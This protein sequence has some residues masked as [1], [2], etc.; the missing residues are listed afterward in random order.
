MTLD[1]VEAR[2]RNLAKLE[3]K[4]QT[5]RQVFEEMASLMGVQDEAI[6][7]LELQIE[8]TQDVTSSAEITA[9][10]AKKYEKRARKASYLNILKVLI[11]ITNFTEAMVAAHHGARVR[12]IHRCCHCN[13][14]VYLMH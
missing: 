8:Q 14:K 3:G 5:M 13:K 10:K 9:T 2:H 12:H 11:E 1:Q 7:R 4:I 6:D